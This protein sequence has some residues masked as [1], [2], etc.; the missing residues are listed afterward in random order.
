MLVLWLW[1]DYAAALITLSIAVIV[2]AVL[3]LALVAEWIEP[4]RVPKRYFWVAL[5]LVGVALGIG[6]LYTI[7]AGGRLDFLEHK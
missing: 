5:V 7:L 6:L 4:S 3:L 2:S 1:N